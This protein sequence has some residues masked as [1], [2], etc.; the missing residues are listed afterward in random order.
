[1]TTAVNFSTV[2]TGGTTTYSWINNTTSIGLATSGNGNI[3]AFTA[4]NSGTSPVTATIIV[5]PHFTNGYVTCDG[6][7]QTFTITVNPTG[8]VD[9][10]S[11]QVVCNGAMT[12]AV[13]FST[14]NT[15]GT[16]TYSWIN[17]TTSIGLATSG[18]GNIAA[19]A[20]MNG[21]TS[22]VT[23]TII[24]TPHFTNGYVTCDGPTK[25]F[26]IIVN[27]TAQVNT[28]GNQVICHNTSATAVAFGTTNTGGAT[29]YTWTNNNASIGLA[30]SSGGNS[31]GIPSF[32]A[33]N[34]GTSPVTATI[35]VTPTFTNGSVSCSGPSTSFTITVNPTPKIITQAMDQNK[36]VGQTAT[37]T[38]TADGLV[39]GYRWQE[40]IGA[41]WNNISNNATYSGATTASLT[42]TGVT[43]SMSGYKYHCIVTGQCSPAATS[44][45]ATLTVN[46]RNTS[47]TYNGVTI[48]QYSDPVALSATLA[49]ISG[50]SPA[51]SLSGRTITFTIGSQSTTALTNSSGVATTSLVITQAPG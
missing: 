3:A 41:A 15:G 37:F 20:A 48:V 30:A 43:L 39:T 44:N 42:I 40:K 32:N 31:T 14:V 35:T 51:V 38:I 16:T 46:K 21:G 2:N 7:T 17:N 22:P 9:Q 4:T 28:I 49:D 11:N 27:P 18:N 33:I 26:T 5:T 19:F 12:T 8:Q 47:L 13:N 36:S 34:N 29:T 45:E 23:A 25:T 50:A 6:P 1:M 24:V 10:P